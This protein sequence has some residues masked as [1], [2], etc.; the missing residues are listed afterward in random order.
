M[1][2]WTPVSRINLGSRG[3]CESGVFKSTAST[4]VGTVEGGGRGNSA[5]SEHNSSTPPIV[6][7]GGVGGRLGSDVGTKEAED[8]TVWKS[9]FSSCARPPILASDGQVDEISGLYV[10]NKLVVVVRYDRIVVQNLKQINQL[11]G[12]Q[13]QCI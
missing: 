4:S 8:D 12:L 7:S 5:E 2:G 1:K 6:L 9:V 3:T 13:Y 11:L 10:V